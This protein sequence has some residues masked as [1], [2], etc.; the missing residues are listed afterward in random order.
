MNTMSP[1]KEIYFVYDGQ[2]PLCEHAALALRIKKDYGALSII[3]ARQETEHEVVKKINGL[4]LDMDEGMVIYCD[5][6]FYHGASALTFMA[7]YSEAKGLFNVVNKVFFWSESV[8]KISY[9][10]LRGIRNWLIRR[11]KIAPI[12]NLSLQGEPIFKPIFGSDWDRLPVVMRKHY[13]NRPYTSDS[14]QADGELDVMCSGPI[15]FFAPLF[16]LFSG[17]PP[18]NE[19]NVPI[20]VDFV[21]DQNTKALHFNRVFKFTKRKHYR[22]HSKMLQTKGNEMVERMRYGLG[23]RTQFVWQDNRVKLLHKGYVWSILGHNI[24][25]PLNTIFGVGYAEE[26][27]V[28]DDTFDMSVTITHPWWGKIYQYNG[29]FKMKA[30]KDKE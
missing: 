9:P 14:Y 3:N 25:L 20:T 7:K 26:V 29:R 28:D 17:I 16:W 21:S 19:K 10:W 2:C 8:V 6:R 13:A 11:K 22:F 23:W 5:D 27:A 18:H 1:N 24:P 15:K 12:D 30:M 4:G